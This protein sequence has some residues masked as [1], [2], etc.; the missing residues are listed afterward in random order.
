MH[1]EL[2]AGCRVM[3]H[4]FDA[5]NF[6]LGALAGAVQDEADQ[7]PVTSR[8]GDGSVVHTTVEMMDFH[9]AAAV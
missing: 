9:S 2:A 7:V 6:P 8:M 5:A 1:A 3:A 4:N